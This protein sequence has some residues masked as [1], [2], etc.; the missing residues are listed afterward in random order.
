MA[1]DITIKRVRYVNFKIMRNDTTG[2]RMTFI[3][4]ADGSAVDK[5]TS[6]FTL[7]VKADEDAVSPIAVLT[8]GVHITT[9][10]VG[11]N[12]VLIQGL[13]AI[14]YSSPFPVYDLQEESATGEITT[15]LK[16]TI[17]IEKDITT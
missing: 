4:R 3:S 15:H 2:I 6:D 9:T 7:T 8:S 12:V 13:E 10:G 1:T 17:E 5:S 11:N 16:G 14:P